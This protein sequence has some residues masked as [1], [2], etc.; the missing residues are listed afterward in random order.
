MKFLIKANL[1]IEVDDH[2][3]QDLWEED[4]VEDEEADALKCAVETF[5][6]A[7]TPATLGH[8][9]DPVQMRVQDVVRVEE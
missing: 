9:F 8:L 7:L 1:E 2:W 6:E 3:L 5:K 4:P